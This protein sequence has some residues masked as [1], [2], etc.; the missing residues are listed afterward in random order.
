MI[1]KENGLLAC[2]IV[3][4]E[5]GDGVRV[6]FMDPSAVLGLV[7]NDGVVALAAEVRQRLERVRDSL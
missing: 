4:R 1:V 3:V 2:N 5:T 6:E 7:D